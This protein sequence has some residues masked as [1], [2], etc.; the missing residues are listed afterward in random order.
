M[1]IGFQALQDV[2]RQLG[3]AWREILTSQLSAALGNHDTTCSQDYFHKIVNFPH[4]KASQGRPV[5]PTICKINVQMSLSIK[6]SAWYQKNLTPS[7]DNRSKAAIILGA[8][9][10]WL[11]TAMFSLSSHSGVLSLT[12]LDAV[13]LCVMI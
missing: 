4:Q 11:S 6:F 10:A 5:A 1:Q 3:A 13:R 7:Y 8:G 12:A 9:A 2:F